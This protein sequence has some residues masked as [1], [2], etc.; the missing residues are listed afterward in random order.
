MGKIFFTSDT[1]FCHDR[2]FIYGPRGFK[3][4]T[5]MN[6]AIIQ[7]WNSIVSPE[8]TVYHL[9]DVMLNNNEQGIRCLKRLNGK[10]IILKGNHDTDTRLCLY[11]DCPNVEILEK[12]ADYFTYNKIKF[13]MS[14]YPTITTNFDEEKNLARATINLF[15]H[16]HQ[17]TNFYL[18][19]QFMYHVGLDSHN[20]Y[21]VDID[22]IIKDIKLKKN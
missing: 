16:T 3:N 19:N 13:Y 12:C 14:H 9:G 20:C 11:S 17:Q 8:D 22:T 6:E 2:D 10:I 7:R 18:G 21:P 15:G 1:H 5:D 4:V